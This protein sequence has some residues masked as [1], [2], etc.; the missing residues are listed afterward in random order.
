MQCCTILDSL[1]AVKWQF[2]AIR[3]HHDS[4]LEQLLE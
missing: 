4:I 3:V 2:A 1:L